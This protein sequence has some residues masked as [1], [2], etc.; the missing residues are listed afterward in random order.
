MPTIYIRDP[1]TTLSV[2]R[3]YF[4]LSSGGK[5]I[6]R[7]PPTMIQ[8]IIVEHGV[9]ITRK[10]LDRLGT[11]G[12]PVTFLGKEGRVQARLV[13][14]WKPDAKGR[15][16]QAAAYFDPSLKMKL[17]RQWIDAKVANAASV[18]RRY[19]SNHSDPQLSSILQDLIRGR[20]AI[21]TAADVPTL[22][23][24]EGIAARK[25]FEAFARMIRVDWLTFSGR[26]RRPP[27]DPGNAVLSYSYA[28]ISNQL[29]ACVE[30]SGL[31]PYI[32]Y[33]HTNESRRPTLV[34][35]LMEPFR[36]ALGDRLTLKLLNLGTLKP[37]HFGEPEGKQNGVRISRE[38]REAILGVLV[39][40]VQECD[41]TLA[42]GP[43]LRSP[44]GLMLDEVERFARHAAS[45]TLGEFVPFHLDPREIRAFTS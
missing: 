36:H 6:G 27:R 23:G 28:V 5:K 30:A 3:S 42:S 10:A 1:K 33:L 39:H 22:M 34:L 2:D 12:I 41:E 11:L 20:D 35:D 18:L 37:E 26:N 40:W 43:N 38:G 13:A 24:V 9:E 17:A 25:W 19:L 31:D 14:P 29:L 45:G 7:I 32:G 8:Q 15:L 44:G 4:T 16:G 21:A